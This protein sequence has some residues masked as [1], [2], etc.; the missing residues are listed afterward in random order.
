MWGNLAKKWRLKAN[1]HNTATCG[2]YKISH[3]ACLSSPLSNWIPNTLRDDWDVTVPVE[4]AESH[5]QAAPPLGPR[6]C[7]HLSTE[8]RAQPSR[9]LFHSLSLSLVVPRHYITGL[10]LASVTTATE[11]HITPLPS[12]Q[13]KYHPRLPIFVDGRSS[14]HPLQR[15]WPFKYTYITYITPLYIFPKCLVNLTVSHFV[16]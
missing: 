5:L 11:D 3:I 2:W 9:A 4:A 7:K 16:K 8:R 15:I 6:G 12:T 14:S 13:V 10:R 1:A